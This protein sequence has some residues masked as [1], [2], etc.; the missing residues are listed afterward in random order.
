LLAK[1]LTIAAFPGGCRREVTGMDNK[2]KH[3]ADT[4]NNTTNK[5]DSAQDCHN[6]ASNNTANNK[7]NK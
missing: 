6:N 7:K 2:K 5:T 4:T 3:N 1:V